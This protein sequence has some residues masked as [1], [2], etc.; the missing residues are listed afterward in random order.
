MISM[1][2]IP[3][4]IGFWPKLEI[5][6]LLVINDHVLAAVVAIAFSVV[7]LVYYLKVVKEMYFTEATD[8]PNVS[9]S[10]SL[11][12]AIS[13]NCLLLVIFGLMP[14]RIYY[15]CLSAFTSLN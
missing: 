2:G 9:N 1:A 15:Y 5:F 3:P 11:K 12:I 8:S 14:D 6:R 13:V 10:R 7:G 4:L